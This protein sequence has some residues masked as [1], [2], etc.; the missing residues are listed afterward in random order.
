MLERPEGAITEEQRILLHRKS[1][2]SAYQWTGKRGYY[3]VIKASGDLMIGG[4]PHPGDRD[5]HKFSFDWSPSEGY[6]FE[7][8]FYALAYSLKLKSQQRER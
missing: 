1:E 6:Y 8:Y 2:D 3:V 5:V 4:S 7:N